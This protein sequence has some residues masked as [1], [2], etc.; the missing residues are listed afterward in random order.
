MASSLHARL[1]VFYWYS[2]WALHH[3][4]RLG[5]NRHQA[6]LLASQ[7]SSDFME[8]PRSHFPVILWWNDCRLNDFLH[9]LLALLPKKHCDL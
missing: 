9:E 5:K 1:A 3:L 7:T 4:G 8:K 6:L 2:H